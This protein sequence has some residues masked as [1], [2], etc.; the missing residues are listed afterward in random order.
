VK[1]VIQN[2]ILGIKDNGEFIP[3]KGIITHVNPDADALLTPAM[4]EYL[5]INFGALEFK[6]SGKGGLVEGKTAE[7]WLK[8][9]WILVD[10]GGGESK[11][12]DLGIT[13]FDHHPP[14]FYPEQCAMTIALNF[15]S[16]EI[17]IPKETM[18][19][20]EKLARFVKNWDIHGGQGFLDLSHICKTLSNK[21]P[22]EILY[23]FIK[24]AM[25]ALL[26]EE[27]GSD[28]KL[29]T[30][31]FSEFSKVRKLPEPLARYQKNLV[32]GKIPNIPNLLTITDKQT[33]AFVKYVLEEAYHDQM[34]FVEA[35][36]FFKEAKKIPLYHDK[37]MVVAETDNN[38]FLKV[39]LKNGATII[40][41]KNS[42]GH[43]Q[44]FTQKRDNVNVSDI[45]AAIRFEELTLFDSKSIP[46]NFE[47]LHRDGTSSI[48][49]NWYLFKQGGM[50]LNG[51]STTPDQ[52][53]TALF[54][55]SITDIILK[56]V[57]NYMPSC[58]RGIDECK[59]VKCP[60]YQW[61]LERCQRKYREEGS[62]R[63]RL[64]NKKARKGEIP[65]LVQ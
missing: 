41:I 25:I 60:I 29:L 3:S 5:G 2:G 30:E 63:A 42:T 23:G 13:H 37:F 31:I 39:S 62:N 22:P 47:A 32:A 59:K 61:G 26:D 50:L 9:R 36:E 53:P 49:T 34:L 52:E 65:I 27:M 10:V 40:V 14:T 18:E 64:E 38:Q 7:E 45:A 54:L 4:L 56:V 51:S 1:I 58:N 15:V 55:D 16:S 44:I 33:V 48:S 12:Q 11:R 6:S 19:K 24:K 35:E 46:I 8:D 28:A 43:V 21:V 57:R 20:L 17:E